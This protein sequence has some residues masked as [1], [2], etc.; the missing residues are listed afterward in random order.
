MVMEDLYER[1][2]N[3]V[4]V[5]NKSYFIHSS[6][7]LRCWSFFRRILWLCQKIHCP[8]C[9]AHIYLRNPVLL[10]FY[11]CPSCGHSVGKGKASYLNRRLSTNSVHES[12]HSNVAHYRRKVIT[13]IALLIS[14]FICAILLYIFNL[15]NGY[16]GILLIISSIP[17]LLSVWTLRCPKCGAWIAKQTP[18]WEFLHY[19]CKICGFSADESDERE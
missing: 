2:Q 13:I 11:S 1:R 12:K 16:C 5:P 8:F 7:T 9:G 18:I 3:C 17:I 10:Y 14:W 15:F 6:C 4:L 19:N